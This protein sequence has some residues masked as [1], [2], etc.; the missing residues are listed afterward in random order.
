MRFGRAVR[1]MLHLWLRVRV[2][3]TCQGCVPGRGVRPYHMAPVAKRGRGSFHQAPSLLP[4]QQGDVCATN[5]STLHAFH[6]FH[7]ESS[8]AESLTT[9]ASALTGDC[10]CSRNHLP[11]Q[12]IL[13]LECV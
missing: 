11:V 5:A 10:A 7:L 1:V 2:R 8:N 3:G 9:W 4:Y 13:P 12:S 6:L